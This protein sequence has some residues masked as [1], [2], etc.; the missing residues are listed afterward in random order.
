MEKPSGGGKKGSITKKLF[1]KVLTKGLKS[2]IIYR[3]L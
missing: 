1:E 3:L 2:D